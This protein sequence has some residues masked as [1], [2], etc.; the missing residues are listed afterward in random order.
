MLFGLALTPIEKVSLFYVLG[1]PHAAP[2]ALWVAPVDWTSNP[3]P[4]FVAGA[5]QRVAA[6]ADAAVRVSIGGLCLSTAPSCEKRSPV[7]RT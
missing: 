7:R 2:Y 6:G 1:K 4:F 5:C 3:M